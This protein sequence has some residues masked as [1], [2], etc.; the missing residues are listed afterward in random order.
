[1]TK[2]STLFIRKDLTG[3]ISLE[4]YH[5][6][7]AYQT[8]STSHDIQTKLFLIPREVYNYYINKK[9]DWPWEARSPYIRINKFQN[10][11]TTYRKKFHHQLIKYD[12]V[13]KNIASCH[14]IYLDTI[15]A[16]INGN[17]RQAKLITDRI[18]KIHKNLKNVR[19]KLRKTILPTS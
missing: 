5:H 13:L 19:M 9:K 7:R 11:L 4:Q 8:T 2:P 10:F 17:E 3:L 6:W 15:L 18:N 14:Y 1:M 12:T 16:I